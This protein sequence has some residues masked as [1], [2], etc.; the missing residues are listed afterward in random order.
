MFTREVG[1]RQTQSPQATLWRLFITCKRTD[2][3]SLRTRT[4]HLLKVYTFQGWMSVVDSQPLLAMRVA[5]YHTLLN[6]GAFGVLTSIG[7][8]S[9]TQRQMKITA[10][11]NSILTWALVI[12]LSNQRP[13][14]VRVMDLLNPNRIFATYLYLY[15]QTDTLHICRQSSRRCLRRRYKICFISCFEWLHYERTYTY[16]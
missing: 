3:A 8:R 12:N 13:I 7:L 4:Y 14:S 10:I 15:Y 11:L 1:L 9:F 2:R 6:P 16:L 5:R